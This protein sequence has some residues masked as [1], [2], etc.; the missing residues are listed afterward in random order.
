MQNKSSISFCNIKGKKGVERFEN[1]RNK[2][3]FDQTACRPLGYDLTPK[4]EPHW[5]PRMTLKVS[6]FRGSNFTRTA[7]E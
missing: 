5:I 3:S 7:R 1:Q 6:S 4:L 2:A